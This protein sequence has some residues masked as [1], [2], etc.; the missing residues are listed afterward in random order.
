MPR[1]E[2]YVV[3]VQTGRERR[4][5]NLIAAVCTP[6]VQECFFPRFQT[7]RKVRGEWEFVERLLLPGYVI[8]VTARPADVAQQLRS[9]PDF[10]RMVISGETYAPLRRD[11]R[12]WVEENTRSGD[13]VVPMSFGYKRGDSF[14]ATSGPLVGR[15]G[16]VTHVNRAKSLAQVEFHV[17]AITIRATVG[18]GIVGEEG[19]EDG[20][21]KGQ[22]R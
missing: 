9:I 11:E 16:L 13:R 21:G 3:Q 7:Q 22:E 4:M 14:V 12:A 6:E 17:D 18:L 1:T 5:C 19:T 8:V 10:C 2:W 15:E 20:L